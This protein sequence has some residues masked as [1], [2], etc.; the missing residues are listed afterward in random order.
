MKTYLIVLNVVLGIANMLCVVC[1]IFSSD[2]PLW[3]FLLN[4]FVG[5]ACIHSSVSLFMHSDD[6]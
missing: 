1:G 2:W 5:I 3:L 6:K 4:L